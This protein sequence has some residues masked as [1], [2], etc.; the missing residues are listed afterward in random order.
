MRNAVGKAVD[1][2]HKDFGQRF[3]S[4]LDIG[5]EFLLEWMKG[6]HNNAVQQFTVTHDEVHRRDSNSLRAM[7]DRHPITESQRKHVESLF[8]A[9]VEA[10]LSATE[11]RIADPLSL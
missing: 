10:E 2:L 11:Q 5:Q 8:K 6:Q 1:L 7:M 3:R 4:S 9:Q